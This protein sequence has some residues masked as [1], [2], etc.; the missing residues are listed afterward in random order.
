[1]EE[2]TPS[3]RPTSISQESA[4]AEKEL[5]PDGPLARDRLSVP[6][7]FKRTWFCE[8]LAVAIVVVS[9][10]LWY[11]FSQPPIGSNTAFLLDPYQ[12]IILSTSLFDPNY[13]PGVFVPQAFGMPLALFYGAFFIPTGGSY[14]VA[15]FSSVV[16]IDAC[17]GLCLLRMVS[18]WLRR[19]DVSAPYALFAVLVY[20][21]NAYRTLSGFGTYGGYFSEG[22]FS[23]GSV[24]PLLILAYLAY[25]TIFVRR[26]FAFLLGFAS[27]FL[28]SAFPLGTITLVE[29][30][31]LIVG[32]LI[33][34]RAATLSPGP[35]WSARVW[36]T[37]S[38]GVAVVLAVL[39]AN[40]YQLLPF[41][42]VG[43]AYVGAL[44]SGNPVYAFS[45]G[46]DSIQTMGNSL[47]LISNWGIIG[48]F[49]GKALAPV[50]MAG[51]LSSPVVQ[52]LLFAI[53][54]LAL[55]SILFLRRLADRLA[56]LLMLVTIL[57]S[58]SSNP[59]AGSAFVWVISALP[60]LRPFYNGETFSPILLIF[61]AA[62]AS[63]TVAR[64]V[65]FVETRA[66]QSSSHNPSPPTPTK[67]KG[68]FVRRIR[69]AAGI[70]AFLIIVGTVLLS[71]YPAL[72]STYMLGNPSAPVASSLPQYYLDANSYLQQTDPNGPVM[73]FPSAPAF[74]GHGA[75]NQSWYQGINI[76]PS[77]IPNPSL[78]SPTSPVA[79]GSPGNAESVP[80]F[81]YDIQKTTPFSG[82][83]AAPTANLIASPAPYLASAGADLVTSNSS[84]VAWKSS[85]STDLLRFSG[86]YPNE[87][88]EYRINT[89]DYIPNGHWLTGSFPA[90]QDLSTFNYVIV[91]W[92]SQRLDPNELQFG[93]HTLKGSTGD[94]Y[95]L[96]DYSSLQ[97]GSVNFTVI[98]LA[99]PTIEGG[100]NLSHV[101][102]VFFVYD[103]ASAG[104]GLGSL[105]VS[106]LFFSS[107][108][109][110]LPVKW[111]EGTAEDHASVLGG[112]NGSIL[113]FI[114][115]TSTYEANG[116][117]AL[118]F[119]PLP[120]NLSAYSFV[121][122]NY[123]LTNMNPAYLQFGFHSGKNEHATGNGYVLGS[124]MTEETAANLSTAV[125]LNSPTVSGG[126]NLSA[127]LN[128]FFVYA[129]PASISRGNA[130]LSVS[131]VWFC[132]GSPTGAALLANDLARLG[133]EF[134]Y[135]DSST[136][137]LA[138]PTMNGSYYNQ[139]F[140]GS[141][142]FERGFSS[143]TVS[144]YR[145]LLYSGPF[146][147]ESN[148]T[149]DDGPPIRI[150]GMYF[151][152]TNSYFNVSFANSSFLST[153]DTSRPTNLSSAEVVHFDRISPTDYSV[154]VQ[155][156]GAFL[157]VFREAYS[158]RWTAV[159]AGAG[160]LSGPL[161]VDGSNDG[162][163]VPRG[164][165]T[166]VITLLGQAV[167]Q[168]AETTFLAI[169]FVMLAL[170]LFPA[171]QYPKR[172]LTRFWKSDQPGRIGE[173][174]FGEVSQH[175]SGGGRYSRPGG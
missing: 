14:S 158:A 68:R 35:A 114:V 86:A 92:S 32:V 71:V 54:L 119:L 118:G 134:A 26:R 19:H 107:S 28:F 171:L 60:I 167:Y 78:S 126:G 4:G 110:P 27:F 47:R 169:P 163:V 33:L 84:Q 31:A 70:L 111:V 106:G 160:T 128:V 37:L 103:P 95:I 132:K 93:Y 162:W 125:A 157:L 53:P 64:A 156:T 87:S 154:T 153:S 52:F 20:S 122:V 6:A 18:L 2:P 40:L 124:F 51:Y 147:A 96:S 76:F 82:D 21:F 77:L 98:P 164:V 12:H 131:A 168:V 55:V 109:S 102:D 46:F 94:A 56:Y 136:Q 151:N 67:L 116:H 10:L 22:L 45:F 99:D 80:G 7:L 175:P 129:P 139:L 121:M 90:A 61:Y 3:C 165:T 173:R 127:V 161:L 141:P 174:Y 72:S 59:P 108:Q 97:Y 170:F 146:S 48:T 152:F 58:T 43:N 105:N 16:I 36:P 8:L 50:W 11:N 62:F 9:Y 113:K 83:C 143:G 89:S 172:L 142:L 91:R 155:S 112:P 81:I 73:V 149:T 130:S 137:G 150:G 41:S 69:R 30:F 133:I 29:E 13:W 140:S 39:F 104:S 63:L 101:V 66:A 117:W 1:M 57:L 65:S 24:A 85:F 5:R 75:G 44:S 159:A 135:V 115:N 17:G 79:I 15:V 34:Y 166:I 120:Q 148:V 25:L 42:I 138:I 145:D 74:G 144:I 123:S 23:P 38:G 100:G 49:S 88:M